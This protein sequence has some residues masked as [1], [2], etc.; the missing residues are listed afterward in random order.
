MMLSK[1]SLGE[2]SLKNEW[3]ADRYGPE[4][5]DAEM[6]VREKPSETHKELESLACKGSALAAYRLG[7]VFAAGKI[8]SENPIEDAI[9]WLRQ[10]SDAGQMSAAYALSHYLIQIGEYEEAVARLETLASQG[11]AAAYFRLG[12]HFLTSDLSPSGEKRAKAEFGKGASADHLP[13]AIWYHA[14]SAKRAPT[15]ANKVNHVVRR[16]LVTVKFAR[17]R[18]FDRHNPRAQ[19]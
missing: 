1:T 15:L 8:P 14:M 9:V 16:A 19:L 11:L 6:K 13:S 17:M 12:H 5:W 10:A 3:E 4:V 7:C 18:L 2:T